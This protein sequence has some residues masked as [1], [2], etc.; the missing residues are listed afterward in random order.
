MLLVETI[1]LKKP[2]RTAFFFLVTCLEKDITGILQRWF[3]IPSIT[4]SIK[5]AQGQIRL[6]PFGN[7]IFPQPKMCLG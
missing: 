6:I 7:L 2:F 5:S 1:L 4:I 3:C